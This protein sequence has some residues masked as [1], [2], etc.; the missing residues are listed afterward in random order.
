MSRRSST[1]LAFVFLMAAAA[2]LGGCTEAASTAS[3]TAGAGPSV[4]DAWVRPP[5]GPDRPAA[6]YLAADA[7]ER[8]ELHRTM[9]D[10]SGM[11]GMESVDGI[12]VPASTTVK[13]E[14]GGLHLML[15][16]LTVEPGDEVGLELTFSSGAVVTIAAAVRAG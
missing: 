13:L 6:G 7:A 1:I 5:M 10:D 12:D 16:G 9:A 14:P 2:V 15:F 4:R 3:G 8:V 11:M